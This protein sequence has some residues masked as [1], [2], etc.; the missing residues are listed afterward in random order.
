MSAFFINSY[1]FRHWIFWSTGRSRC[2]RR[3]TNVSGELTFSC[4]VNSSLVLSP[5][6]PLCGTPSAEHPSPTRDPWPRRGPLRFPSAVQCSFQAEFGLLLRRRDNRPLPQPQ[7]WQHWQPLQPCWRFGPKKLTWCGMG[8]PKPPAYL[9]LLP[10]L[11]SS[12]VSKS[13]VIAGSHFGIFT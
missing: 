2:R 12:A 4:D 5:H 3:V 13:K 11:G 6:I 10:V 9:L 1:M 8:W 7:Q